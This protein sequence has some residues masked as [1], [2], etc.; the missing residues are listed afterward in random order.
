MI[1]QKLALDFIIFPVKYVL[2]V[3]DFTVSVSVRFKER[4][5]IITMQH[6]DTS[7]LE[8]WPCPGQLMGLRHH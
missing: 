6:M 7:S 4:P 1:L 3:R 5:C 8:V 2:L